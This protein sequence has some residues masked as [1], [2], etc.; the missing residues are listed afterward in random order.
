[1]RRCRRRWSA[2]RCPR[3]LVAAAGRRAG[4]RRAA[5]RR[6]ASGQRT[7]T[8]TEAA[9][10]T[11]IDITFKG[12]TVDPNGE[13][14]EGQ[15]GRA[16]H[17]AHH[18][19]QAGRAA[20]AQLRPSRRSSTTPA[21]R[22]RRS[23]STSPASSRSSRTTSRQLVVQL[24]VALSLS[25]DDH[26]GPRDRRRQG[27]A[28]P[29]GARDRGRRSPRWSSPSPCW[30]WPGARRATT[31]ATGGRPAPRVARRRGRRRPRF[32]SALRVAR[33]ACSSSTSPGA[34]ISARTCSP[35]RS[36]ARSTCWSGSGIVPASLLFGPV[37]QGDQPG[38]HASTCCWPSSPAATRTVGLLRLPR[39]ARLLAGGARP[40]RLRLAG[41][42]LPAQHRARSG[43]DLAARRTSR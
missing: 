28:D 39:P 14:V 18:G 20:R 38:A 37:W 22:P 15:G 41:A 10:G 6:A 27:P 23:P 11:T 2:G 17:A 5:P 31:S 36:S 43:A 7:A 13:R 19:R 30:R 24:E 25:P 3:L 1:M 29:A 26:A 33:P 9:D 40:V 42:G 34:L 12:D 4:G 16:D 32:R 21:P 35:T 8:P